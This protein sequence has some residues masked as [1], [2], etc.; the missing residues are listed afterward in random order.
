MRTTISVRYGV[1]GVVD[2]VVIP[3]GQVVGTLTHM[4]LG[5]WGHDNP[6]SG[7]QLLP[8]LGVLSLVVTLVNAEWHYEKGQVQTAHFATSVP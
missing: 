2:V 1:M 8:T 4:W 3:R 7:Q 5:A 6:A